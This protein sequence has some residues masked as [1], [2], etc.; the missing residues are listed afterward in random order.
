MKLQLFL[1]RSPPF[2]ASPAPCLVPILV[3]SQKKKKSEQCTAGK[4]GMTSQLFLIMMAQLEKQGIGSFA[5]DV[6]IPLGT[7]RYGRP[8]QNEAPC[9]VAFYHPSQSQ[10]TICGWL[11]QDIGCLAHIDHQK[12]LLE[13][14][15]IV[16]QRYS[17]IL[18]G[19]GGAQ[20]IRM[21]VFPSHL[22]EG[23]TCF[24]F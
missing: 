17:H 16:Q 2:L 9:R 8:K 22:A 13:V 21:W 20:R 14:S 6:I 11:A 5:L 15:T 1:P 24:R 23:C 4:L 3:P 7:C 10:Y 12:D 19:G 18:K